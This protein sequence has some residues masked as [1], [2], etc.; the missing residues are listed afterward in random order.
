M[1]KAYANVTLW[2]NMAGISVKGSP[3]LSFWRPVFQTSS[4]WLRKET[5]V[6]QY[7]EQIKFPDLRGAAFPLTLFHIISGGKSL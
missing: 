1:K 3:C 7:Y 5:G 6:E 4:F 2:M